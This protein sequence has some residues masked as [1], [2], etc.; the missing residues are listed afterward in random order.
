M[1]TNLF[2]VSKIF[3]EKIL[4]IPDYQRGY[5][6]LDKHLKDFWMDI[7]QLEFNKNHYVGVLTL[8]KVP[9]EKYLKWEAD[10]WIIQSKSFEAFYIVD[11]QQRLTTTIILIQ[12]IIESIN[13]DKKLNF[14][15]IE[16]I[17]K[18]YLFDSKDDGISKTY[19]LGYETDNPSY[20]FLKNHIFNEEIKSSNLP[21][22]TI[23]T[24]NLFYAKEYFLNK[25]K[26]MSIEE[27]E[28]IFKK[29]T[30]N[31][32]FNIYVMSEDVDVY[33]AF[34]TMN[35]RGKALSHLELLKNRLIYLSTKLNND[36]YEIKALRNS[37]NECWKTIY[38]QLGRNKENPLDDDQFLH[39]HFATY[40][41]QE[42]IN[43]TMSDYWL[44]YKNYKYAYQDYLLE[45]MFTT[46]NI[47]NKT[48]S[49]KDIYNYVNSLKSSVELWYELLNPDESKFEDS[50]RL[51]LNKISKLKGTN[52]TPL[53]LVFFQLE[54]NS[55]VRFKFLK[56]LERYL[57][58]TK[59]PIGYLGIFANN[60]FFLELIVKLKSK[61]KDIIEKVISLINEKFDSFIG[62]NNII[63]YS[64]NFKDT[65]FYQWEGIKYVLYEYEMSLKLNSKTDR[66][67]IDSKTFFSYLEEPFISDYR[68][69]EHILPQRG[70]KKCW[71]DVLAKYNHEEKRIIKNL[72]GNLVPLSSPKNSSLSNECFDYK[73]DNPIHKSVGFRYGSYSENELT[74]FKKWTA[75]EILIRSVKL[76]K[77]IIKNWKIHIGKNNSVQ[78]IIDF[79]NSDFILKKENLLIENE[80]IVKK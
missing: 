30:Q 2:S 18:K 4:R 63:T 54:K 80:R 66:E 6:W 5:A 53:L 71:T 40:F 13:K 22:E 15:S 67:K 45:E 52:F 49:I 62:E 57:F 8:E 79:L 61:E 43:D 39:N 64:K 59:F 41:E 9:K 34:E 31:F 3:T 47:I 72:I 76:I 42:K 10:T 29:I 51:W 24:N 36:E 28:I 74:K 17:Q 38:H 50:E 26:E 35:N 65:G 75:E 33:V 16:E 68:S 60:K 32:L 27:I 46:K 69:I 7:T 14:S 23:Y 37:I 70:K 19:L 77:F 25:L 58:I 78:E 12:S 56:T 21:Q 11:G 20:E 1:E 44:Y 73:I 55:E 48:I